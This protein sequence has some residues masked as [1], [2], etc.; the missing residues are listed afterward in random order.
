VHTLL[1]CAGLILLAICGWRRVGKLPD[2]PKYL[3]IGAPH[4]SYWDAIYGMALA[5][6]FKVEVFWMA[7]DSAF[8]WPFGVFVKWLGGIPIDRSRRHNMVSQS[9]LEFEKS[10]RLILA[11]L[12]E[13]TRDWT[14]SWK[15]GFYHIA[16][17]AGVPV[18]TAFLDY[19]N[20]IGGFGPTIT[21]TGDMDADMRVIESFYSTKTGRHPEKAGP[22]R[23]LPKPS[24]T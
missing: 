5:L 12:P 13:G 24:D 22:I 19:R 20:K 9:I 10:D 2:A 3:I 8:P 14:A 16:M 21:L 17:G 11:I 4:T 7:K 23:I 15:T 18:A 1:K 6:S